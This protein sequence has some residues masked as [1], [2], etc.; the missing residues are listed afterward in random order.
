MDIEELTGQDMSALLE[1]YKRIQED[2]GMLGFSDYETR[3]YVALVALRMSDAESLALLAQIPRTSIYKVLESL[4]K[5]GYVSV[6]EGRPRRYNAEPPRAL[7]ERVF[8][9]LE[10]TFDD[11]ETVHG[12]L[13]ERGLPQIIYTINGKDKVLTKIAELLDGCKERFM[14]SSSNASLLVEAL[15]RSIGSAQKRGVECTLITLP[16]QRTVPGAR[17][18]RR[19]G[20]IATDLVV[21]GR[22]A[23]IA[24]A[25]LG[26]CGFTDNEVLAQHL[27]GFLE[28]MAGE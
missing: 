24:S 15:E 19:Q 16:G 10:E 23:L 26:A 7:R 2:M 21:D 18:I 6:T 25:D 20:L 11:L 12:I 22:H 17:T 3:A 4:V 9:R 13:R 27:E 8:A 1:R 28:I 5:K 14:L